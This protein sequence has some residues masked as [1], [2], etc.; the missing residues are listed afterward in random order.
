MVPRG[1]ALDGPRIRVGYLRR[2]RA[3]DGPRKRSVRRSRSNSDSDRLPRSAGH[4]LFPLGSQSRGRKASMSSLDAS[5]HLGSMLVVFASVALAIGSSSG[6]DAGS[7][8]AS[9]ASERQWQQPPAHQAPQPGTGCGDIT[10][11][12]FRAICDES[13]PAGTTSVQRDLWECGKAERV[14]ALRGKKISWQGWV[15][16]VEQVDYPT[17]FTATWSAESPEYGMNVRAVM[18]G[19]RGKRIQ[20][21]SDAFFAPVVARSANGRWLGHGEYRVSIDM[22]DPS[23][24]W[25]IPELS[26]QIPQDM[27][28]VLWI[29]RVIWIEGIIRDPGGGD[30]IHLEDG[31]Q[32]SDEDPCGG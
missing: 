23:R 9:W 4:R 1:A 27:A 21:D 7:D 25:S 2:A 12:A 19:R 31:W 8:S 32:L 30:S 14:A 28:L 29:D 15:E 22:D 16:D 13:P 3:S 17:F 5:R 26:F 24:T 11:A 10:F 20:G 6:G 18:E